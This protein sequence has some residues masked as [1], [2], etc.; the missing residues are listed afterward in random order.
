MMLCHFS[1]SEFYQNVLCLVYVKK[2][3]DSILSWLPRIAEQI[4]ATEPRKR[5]DLSTPQPPTTAQ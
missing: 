4:D 3:W 5:A 1:R 2:V